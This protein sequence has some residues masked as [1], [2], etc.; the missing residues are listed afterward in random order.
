MNGNLPHS[1]PLLFFMPVFALFPPNPGRRTILLHSNAERYDRFPQSTLKKTQKKKHGAWCVLSPKISI[2]LYFIHRGGELNFSTETRRK[3]SGS[4]A[5]TY[6][7]SLIPSNTI[8]FAPYPFLVYHGT[9]IPE[10]CELFAFGKGLRRA[11]SPTQ[12]CPK[13]AERND[14]CFFAAATRFTSPSR[15][16][17]LASNSS[18]RDYLPSKVGL[19]SRPTSVLPLPATPPL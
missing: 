12:L 3:K 19:H 10:T 6:F 16:T 17:P 1:L 5:Q 13:T 14:L 2:K 11:F 8:F 18:M 7:F 9:T 4:T 15:Q